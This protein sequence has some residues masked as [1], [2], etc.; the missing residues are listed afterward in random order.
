MVAHKFR[1]LC[2]SWNRQSYFVQDTVVGLWLMTVNA[3]ARSSC[4]LKDDE[5]MGPA[6]FLLDVGFDNP[7]HCND[8]TSP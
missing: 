1:I 5:A 2:S 8:R 6:P 7:L 4:A 3:K